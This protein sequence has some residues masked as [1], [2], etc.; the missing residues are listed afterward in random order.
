MPIQQSLQQE[1]PVYILKKVKT[2]ALIPK[3]VSLILLGVIFFL[4]ILINISLLQL[5][6]DQEGIIKISA[7]IFLLAIIGL[8]IF[9]SLHRASMSYKFYRNRITF[10]KKIVYYAN[11]NVINPKQDTIDKMFNTT[12]IP[13]TK[14]FIIK[15]IPNNVQIINYIK[16]VVSYAKQ[17]QVSTY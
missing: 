11:I 10:G 7:I 1:K 6:A 12:T 2:R 15:Q 8:G 4:G 5:R 13:I 9:L 3:I 16:Q 17:G 14:D